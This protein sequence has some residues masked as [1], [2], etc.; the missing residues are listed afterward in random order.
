MPGDLTTRSV[1]LDSGTVINGDGANVKGK[2]TATLGFNGRC[3]PDPGAVGLL[4]TC[5]SDVAE[6]FGTDQRTE[7][8][9]LV[10]FIPEDRT[11]PA[12]QLTTRPYEGAIVGVVSTDPG[13]VFDQGETR[14]SGDNSNLITD[15]K[16]VVAMVGRVPTKFSLENGPIAVGDPLTSS[17]TPGVAMK[18]TQAGQIIGY[19][20]Q[21]S[22][23]AKDGKLLVWLQL[24]AYIPPELLATLNHSVVPN[25]DEYD[26]SITELQTQLSELSAQVVELSAQVDKL[27][28]EQR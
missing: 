8:G 14:L 5:N 10:V 26:L 20:M 16:T 25:E 6:T 17:S 3:A 13:L 22:D 27:Q 15:H 7:P 19:A 11:F 18:A 23:A 28:A 9:D 24:G 4:I 12:V 1:S 2:V 21:S